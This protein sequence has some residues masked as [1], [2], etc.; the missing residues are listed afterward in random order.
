[1][2]I[3]TLLCGCHE[4]VYTHHQGTIDLMSVL[5]ENRSER[6]ELTFRDTMASPGLIIL[7]YYDP[8]YDK[9][10]I[11]DMIEVKE[12]ME[13][14]ICDNYHS[15]AWCTNENIVLSCYS[16]DD[17]YAEIPVDHITFYGLFNANGIIMS[18][19]D[20][21]TECYYEQF[22]DLILEDITDIYINPSH[23]YECD[24]NILKSFPNLT[25]LKIPSKLCDDN[26]EDNIPEKCD[27]EVFD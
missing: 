1:M 3:L 27:V 21:Y 26:F 9:Y 16:A 22:E 6:Y 20:I 5:E 13:N 8:Q 11:Q 10:K 23:V 4:N 17:K 25:H 15:F 7:M 18:N 14:Y 24:N 2:I 12:I 19:M